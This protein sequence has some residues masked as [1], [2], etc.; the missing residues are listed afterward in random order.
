MYDRRYVYAIAAGTFTVLMWASLPLLRAHTGLP[1]MLTAAVAMSA[2]AGVAGVLAASRGEAGSAFKRG[3]YIGAGPVY[4]IGGV[5]G[6]IGALY[7]YFSAL[8]LGDPARITLVTYIWPVGFIVLVNRIQ[9]RPVELHVIFGAAV[10]FAG[11]APL[12]ISDTGAVG[13]PL[14]AYA[15]GVAAGGSW[16]VF[17]LYLRYAGSIPFRGYAR[18]FSH[19]AVGAALLHVSSG[20]SFSGAS[21]L[22][23]LVAGVIGLGPYG[24]AFMSW[25]FALRNG[26]SGLLGVLN[27]FVPVLSASLLVLFGHSQPEPQLATATLAVVAGSMI[28]SHERRLRSRPLSSGISRVRRLSRYGAH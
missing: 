22:E 2:A 5:G 27:Y 10:A 12:I 4:W 9:G 20:G 18:L 13:T 21:P 3:T 19:A 23:W 28:A 6:L 26:P 25:G 17:S 11:V 1:A 15:A 16:I 24:V 7:F 14:I 8:P